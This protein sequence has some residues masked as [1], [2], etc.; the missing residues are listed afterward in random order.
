MRRNSRTVP[1]AL[2]AF[3]LSI[4]GV[5][6]QAAEDRPKD[7]S[8]EKR[9]GASEGGWRSFGGT[10][11]TKKA[12]SGT[13]SMANFTPRGTSGSYQEFPAQPGSRWRLAGYGLAPAK[14]K[15]ASA[16]G[17][18]QLTFF[19]AA[20]KDLGTVETAGNKYPA[21]ASNRIEAGSPANEWILLD[22]GVGT[23]PPG[24][25]TIQVFT[26]YVDYPA[27][28]HGAPLAATSYQGVYFDD[29]KLCELSPDD[30]GSSCK[31]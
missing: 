5:A 13:H 21:L 1:L 11:S 4:P 31:P 16:F 27:A 17:I 8:F 29:L 19:D 9:L 25:A 23:A 30:D 28:L 26:L 18:V 2:L 24:T 10:V 15:G 3:L 14:L 22:T 6:A 12:R 7:A 20:G